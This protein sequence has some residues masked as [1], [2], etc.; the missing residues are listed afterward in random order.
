MLESLRHGLRCNFG[1]NII[2]NDRQVLRRIFGLGLR[3]SL[4]V[5]VNIEVV[6]IRDFS[7]LLVVLV[8]VVADDRRAMRT[9]VIHIHFHSHSARLEYQIEHGNDNQPHST[10]Y[11]GAC[12][13]MPDA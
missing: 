1:E 6:T 3:R 12:S 13:F 7:D 4:V 8:L 5:A 2:D 11:P 9:I 10:T